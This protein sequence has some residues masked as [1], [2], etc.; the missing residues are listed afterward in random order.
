MEQS[1]N[2][3]KYPKSGGIFKNKTENYPESVRSFRANS[4]YKD[5]KCSILSLS[6]V[7]LDKDRILAA[8][9]FSCLFISSLRSSVSVWSWSDFWRSS[10]S[11][12]WR[13]L[14]PWISEIVLQR[15][16]QLPLLKFHMYM[17]LARDHGENP[18]KAILN[19]R[20]SKTMSPYSPGASCI[21]GR[22]RF[23]NG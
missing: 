20:R 4:L 13:V 12:F 21:S 23:S 10:A 18:L 8:F 1:K 5:E 14:K 2:E 16:G 3:G 7:Y 6:W 9:K 11:L 19:F 15:Q 17:C 22:K